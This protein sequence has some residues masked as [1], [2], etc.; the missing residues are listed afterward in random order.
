[1][2][3][4][5]KISL[6]GIAVFIIVMIIIAYPVGLAI[7]TDKLEAQVNEL[8]NQYNESQL[9]LDIS[10]SLL[11]ASKDDYR[12]LYNV[13]EDLRIEYNESIKLI[14]VKDIVISSLNQEINELHIRLEEMSNSFINIYNPSKSEIQMLYRLV[15]SEATGYGIQE[16][17]NVAHVLIN[18]IYSGQFPNTIKE[19]IFQNRQFSVI[20]D[21]RFESVLITKSSI[22]AVDIALRNKDTTY[23]SLYFMNESIS[24]KENSSWFKEKLQFVMNDNSGHSF[25]K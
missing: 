15:E 16:K 23:G 11:G 1:M 17:M 2:S 24:D 19:T 7:N 4:L 9:Q 8:T 12:W 25:Y 18:R 13:N 6:E 22:D 10:D 5:K 14:Q 21:G 20:E 3:R